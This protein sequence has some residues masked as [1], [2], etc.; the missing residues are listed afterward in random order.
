MQTGK[1]EGKKGETPFFLRSKQ[2]GPPLSRR[3]VISPVM[4]RSENR[5]WVARLGKILVPFLLWLAFLHGDGEG[6]VSGIF[7]FQFPW[8]CCPV[9]SH[10]S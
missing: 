7:S 5:S 10:P 3:P 1:K 4:F 9:V 2:D 6:V 8:D